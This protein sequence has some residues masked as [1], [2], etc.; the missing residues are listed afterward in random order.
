MVSFLGRI[1]VSWAGF[2]MKARFDSPMVPMAWPRSFATEISIIKASALVATGCLLALGGSRPTQAIQETT[3]A[4]VATP[5]IAQ[6]YDDVAPPPPAEAMVPLA[7]PGVEAVPQMPI[8]GTQYVVHVGGQSD[9]VLDQVRLVE[10]TAFKTTFEGR[11][12]IQAGRFNSAQ[13]AQQ[14]VLQLAS[15][16]LGSQTVEV[17][18]ATPYYAQ[19]PMPAA[20]TYASNGALPPLPTSALP[21]STTLPPP[22]TSLPPAT[23]VP[24]TTAQAP[25]T[26]V[27]PTATAT[28][29]TATVPA[30]SVTTITTPL[31]PT[32]EIA[33]PPNNVEF[34]QELTYSV[35]QGA[36]AYPMSVDPPTT[37]TA[38]ANP[39]SQTVRAPYYVVIPA[40]ANSL[41][42]VS[43]QVIQLGTPP[44]SVQQR[45][46]P[47]GPHVAVGPF[48][49]RNL[50]NSWSNFYR[51]AGFGGSRVYFDR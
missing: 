41:P 50:A 40:S 25:V 49:D 34:G 23:A 39:S 22:A 48:A 46:E 17:P 30:G 12:V 5:A 44:A 11:P 14:R 31:P 51:Q 47:I 18:A 32:P 45:T 36:N 15:Q 9:R 29:P 7:V 38:A 2:M 43:S 24:T 13:N 33:P 19:S 21:T 6:V 35:P 26:A 28:P 8:S 16:G 1:F 4:Q 37:A 10:P 3:P 42:E 27:P 20:N